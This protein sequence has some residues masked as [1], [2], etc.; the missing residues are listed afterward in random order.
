MTVTERKTWCHGSDLVIHTTGPSWPKK[1]LLVAM[2]TMLPLVVVVSVLFFSSTSVNGLRQAVVPTGSFG[3]KHVVMHAEGI[4][5]REAVTSDGN[6]LK[7]PKKGGQRLMIAGSGAT[8]NSGIIAIFD[9]A[10]QNTAEKI[11]ELSKDV[12]PCTCYDI[13]TTMR[14]KQNCCDKNYFI[15]SIGR[16]FGPG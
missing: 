5:A 16:G 7:A 15:E 9:N 1:H 8:S 13:V 3:L 2:T 14:K 6:T 12:K 10:N 4:G 11:V